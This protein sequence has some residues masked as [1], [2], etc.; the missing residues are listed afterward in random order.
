MKRLTFLF[1]LLL[2]G[3]MVMAQS[4]SSNLEQLGDGNTS[5]VIQTGNTNT[6]FS[7]VDGDGNVTN[8]LQ[9]GLSNNARIEVA[10]GGNTVVCLLYTSPSPRDATLSRMPSSA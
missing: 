3:T 2:S 4:N 8:E 9:E 7:V 10:G 1:A 5:E 6:S